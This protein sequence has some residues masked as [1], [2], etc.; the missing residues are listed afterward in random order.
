MNAVTE[1]RSADEMLD[2]LE[3]EIA[4]HLPEAKLL[5]EHFFGHET[6]ARVLHIPAGTVLTGKPHRF[7]TINILLKGKIE[8]TASNEKPRMLEAPF[9][10]VAE[11]GARRAG[12]VH[13]DTI[14]VNIHHTKETDLDRIEAEQIIPR[15][16]PLL[17]YNTRRITP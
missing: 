14:W 3:V 2:Q 4:K 8:V 15:L 7:R 1:R 9:I 12:R 16:N 6:Y 17:D 13:E 10:F 11:A 5:T